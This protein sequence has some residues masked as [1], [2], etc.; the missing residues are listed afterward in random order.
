MTGAGS[1]TNFPAS[2]TPSVDDSSGIDL[3][4]LPWVIGGGFVLLAGGVVAVGLAAGAAAKHGL[5][6]A[7]KVL[8]HYDAYQAAGSDAERRVAGLRLAHVAL[9][10]EAAPDRR[11]AGIGVRQLANVPRVEDWR[12]GEDIHGRP[13]I[14]GRVYGKPGVPDGETIAFSPLDRGDGRLLADAH[15]PDVIHTARSRYRLGRPAR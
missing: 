6:Y 8:P 2:A 3:S 7:L 9:G 11:D 13:E 1:Q 15:D 12:W 14:R 4:W 5:P 10:G